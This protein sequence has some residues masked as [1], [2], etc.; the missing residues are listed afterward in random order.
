VRA[1]FDP[2]RG[3][4]INLTAAEVARAGQWAKPV[5]SLA[6]QALFTLGM[7]VCAF[8]P[9]GRARGFVG[10]VVA[11]LAI[12]ALTP[13][14][15]SYPTFGGV[16]WWVPPVL[17]VV[18][19][20]LSLPPRV[21]STSARGRRVAAIVASLVALALLLY[22][23][24]VDPVQIPGSPD[25]IVPYR[26]V[27]FDQLIGG[28]ASADTL[29]AVLGLLASGGILALSLAVTA[30]LAI[31]AVL[32][33]S[34]ALAVASMIVIVGVGLLGHALLVAFGHAGGLNSPG[35]VTLSR[36]VDALWALQPA[37]GDVL[38]S[39]IRLPAAATALLPDWLWRLGWAFQTLIVPYVVGLLAAVIDSGSA[40]RRATT[41][42]ATG[43]ALDAAA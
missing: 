23:I 1:S 21:P 13:T 6:F 37:G 5:A 43:V 36:F 25:V 8:L 26:T 9:A 14:G 4:V 41:A 17:G 3:T 28:L 12:G 2:E 22:P 15:E 30:V 18:A 39:L 42:S 10:A 34:R 40:R 35:L 27:L 29:E 19:A 16:E 11:G 38:R 32:R 20:G 31:A 24:R 7:L 33:R